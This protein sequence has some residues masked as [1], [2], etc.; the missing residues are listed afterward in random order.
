M[1]HGGGCR[2]L[3][4]T[5]AGRGVGVGGRVIMQPQY[6]SVPL[7]TLHDVTLGY[8]RHPAVHHLS[9]VF[10]SQTLTAITGPNGAGKST[11]LKGLMGLMRPMDGVIELH[12]FTT[13]D[14]AYLPQAAE[15]DRSFPITVMDTVAMGLWGRAGAWASLSGPQQDMAHEALCA[16]GLEGFARRPVG[17]LSPGQFQRMLFARLILQDARLILLD[18]PFAAVDARTT[19]TLVGLMHDWHGQGRTVVAVLHELDMAR[20]HFPYCLLLARE[21]VAWGPTSAALSGDNLHRS[22]VMVEAWDEEADI[23]PR[24]QGDA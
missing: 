8:D 14:M 13:R 16:V 12:G 18:E 23:C 22:R 4:G 6:G 10:A 19:E 11:L 1:A 24:G 9:G 7:I 15:M 5:L 20:S 17:S 2:R 21:A 3:G